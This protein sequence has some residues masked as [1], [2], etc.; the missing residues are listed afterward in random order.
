MISLIQLK[1]NSSDTSYNDMQVPCR[2]NFCEF[3][4]AT[5]G[6]SHDSYTRISHSLR[7]L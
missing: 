1:R 5:A 3:P 4:E 2:E 6:L 7:L